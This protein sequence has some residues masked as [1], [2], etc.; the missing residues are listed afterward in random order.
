MGRSR[1]TPPL[2]EVMRETDRKPEP[3]RVV[4]G[5]GA[6]LPRASEPAGDPRQHAGAPAPRSNLRLSEP[7]PAAPLEQPS[8]ADEAAEPGTGRGLVVGWP[9]LLG[10]IGV[11][12]AVVAIIAT[13]AYNAGAARERDELFTGEGAPP[14]EETSGLPR[15]EVQPPKTVTPKRDPEP[16]PTPTPP[17][18]PTAMAVFGDDPRELGKNYLI[19][20]TLLFDDA[21]AAAEFLTAAGVPSVVVA[22]EG[23]KPEELTKQ[24]RALWQVVVREGFT[25]DEYRANTSRADQIRN[26]VRQVGRRWKADMKGSSDFSNCY[27]NKFGK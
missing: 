25:R 13:L 27:W 20:E 21:M 18:T 23:S 26:S 17:R 1:K 3:S 16:R 19:V 2:F 11:L 24:P 12:V 10:G 22:P 6:I 7:T 14:I 15:N 8:A 5:P 4:T 9:L